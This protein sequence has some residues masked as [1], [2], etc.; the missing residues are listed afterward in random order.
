[1]EVEEEKKV[2]VKLDAKFNSKI[3]QASGNVKPKANQTR[4][5]RTMDVIY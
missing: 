1:M 5:S 2:L 3:D 4:Q